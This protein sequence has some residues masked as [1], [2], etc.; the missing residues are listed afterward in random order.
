MEMCILDAEN[1]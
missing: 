1:V